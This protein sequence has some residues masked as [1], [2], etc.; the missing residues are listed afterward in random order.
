MKDSSYYTGIFWSFVSAFLW[1]TTFIAARY[2]LKDS[3]IDPISLATFRFI[4]GAAALF[5]LGCIF[6]RKKMFNVKLSDLLKLSGLSLL[7]VV[8]MCV[9]IFAGQQFTTAI[10]S[11]VITSISPI[12]ILLFGLF[13]GEKIRL[14]QIAGI[15]LSLPGGL[16]VIGVLNSG[17]MN[18]SFEY[19]K[20]DL[21]VLCGALSWALYSVFSKPL[22]LRLGGFTATVWGLV[23]GAGE[24]IILRIIWPQPM[25]IPPVSSVSL[26]WLIIYLG[27]FPGGIAFFA[28]YEAMAKIEL[29]LLNIMQYLTPVFT[30][31]L[32]CWLLGENVS[33]LNFIGIIMVLTGVI[34]NSFQKISFPKKKKENKIQA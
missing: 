6:F 3:L 8:G 2:L 25:I 26:W 19:F 17:G 20:G 14:N 24:L 34:L 10:N 27:I 33:L 5:I 7:G 4:L 12:F 22:V 28:W 9:F 23:A 15:F 32:A 11:A 30:I 21:L 1:G 13:I 18:Y 31:I 16:L 29:S